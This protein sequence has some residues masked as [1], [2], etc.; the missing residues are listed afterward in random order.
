V[1]FSPDGTRLASAGHDHIVKVWDVLRGRELSTQLGHT[2]GIYSVA[3]SP[4]GWQIASASLDVKIK[5]WDATRSPGPRVYQGHDTQV[6]GVAFSPDGRSLASIGLDG[7]IKVRDAVTGQEQTRFP[8]DRALDGWAGLQ[9]GRSLA[10]QRGRRY[11]G[12]DL[13]CAVRDAAAHAKRSH[14]NR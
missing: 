6:R 7:R 13:G 1:A 12:E 3:F 14:Q 2:E 8:E 5:L 4:D 11:D 10:R 9:P